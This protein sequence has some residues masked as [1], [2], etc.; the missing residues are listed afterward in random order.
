[1]AQYA[2]LS[3]GF[4]AHHTEFHSHQSEDER[5]AYRDACDAAYAADEDEP[6]D[7]L[8]CPACGHDDAYET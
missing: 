3:C 7:D 5:Q 1:M 2:C 4:T 8:E 6:D